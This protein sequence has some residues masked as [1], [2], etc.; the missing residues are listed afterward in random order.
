MGISD[1][2]VVVGM[3][4]V[5]AVGVYGLCNGVIKLLSSSNANST[6]AEPTESGTRSK[7]LLV[8]NAH[9]SSQPV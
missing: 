2:F 7:N 5:G 3:Q 4:L 1:Q 6:E 9:P 8:S